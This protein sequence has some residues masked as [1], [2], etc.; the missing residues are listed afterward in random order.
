MK[1][2]IKYSVFFILIGVLV[3]CGLAAKKID[4]KSQSQKTDVFSEVKKEGIPAKGFADLIIKT[5]IKTHVGG[6][7]FIEP[8]KT[9]HGQEE[10]PILI[11]IDGQAMTW[12]L[13][14]QKEVIPNQ[15]GNH[16]PEEGEGMRYELNKRIRLALGPH[17]IFFGLPGE[18]VYKEIHLTFREGIMNVLEF[19]PIYRTGSGESTR[20]FMHGVDGGELFFNGNNIR[21]DQN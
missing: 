17:Q 5:S 6:Y 9:F 1:I 3:G 18:K 8:R 11:N 13:K 19:K 14:G 12:K 2:S 20:S 10:Y 4:L 16:N 7:Y 15:K 21:T